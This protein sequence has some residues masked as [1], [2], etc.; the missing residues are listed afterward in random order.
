MADRLGVPETID[1]IMEKRKEDRRL[2]KIFLDIV[3]A[4][5][6]PE[7]E[8][9][10]PDFPDEVYATLGPPRWTILEPHGSPPRVN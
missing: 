4:N 2:Y 10:E 6:P 7:V 3:E 8:V 9:G 5:F 1:K